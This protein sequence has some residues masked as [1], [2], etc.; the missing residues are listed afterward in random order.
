MSLENGGTGATRR[1]PE[2]RR[3]CVV[4]GCENIHQARGYCRKHYMAASRAGE[5]DHEPCSHAGCDRPGISL[6]LCALHYVRQREGRDMDAPI[7][8]K[9]PT[10]LRNEDGQKRCRACETWLNVGEFGVATRTK[11]GLN[12]LCKRCNR[13]RERFRKYQ[14]TEDDVLDLLE[15]QGG[16]CRICLTTEPDARGWQVDHDHKHCPTDGSGNAV[17]CGLCIRGVLCSPCN[18]AIGLLRDDV[19]ALDRAR[20]YL[21]ACEI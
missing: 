7:Q 19:A 21:T 2:D 13:S 6:G 20:A 3:S 4:D 15:W 1:S 18:T 17:T 12:V 10:D 11:D 14:M 16:H 9:W 5:F 8:E